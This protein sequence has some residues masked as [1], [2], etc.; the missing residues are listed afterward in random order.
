MTRLGCAL[1]LV[2][3]VLLLAIAGP[4][5]ADSAKYP[6][7]GLV[8][9]GSAT[10]TGTTPVTVITAS[11]D[12]S[13]ASGSGN[14]LVLSQACFQV[15]TGTVTLTAGTLSVPFAF[16]NA[17]GGTGCQSF[18]PGYVIPEGTDVACVATGT[19]GFTCSA[20]GVVTKNK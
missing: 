2:T 13:T 3:P 1:S 14:V 18:E 6:V 20:S 11:T 16:A 17:N 7:K 8:K 15:T 12:P 5:L 9:S 4:S 10:G 19:A